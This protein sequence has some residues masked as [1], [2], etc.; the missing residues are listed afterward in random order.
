M[1]VEKIARMLHRRPPQGR[2]REQL[3]WLVDL[4][5]ACKSSGD[6]ALAAEAQLVEDALG[7]LGQFLETGDRDALESASLRVEQFAQAVKAAVGAN[8]GSEEP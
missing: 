4:I 8:K 3:F 7:L 2:F 6:N 1:S 5:Y